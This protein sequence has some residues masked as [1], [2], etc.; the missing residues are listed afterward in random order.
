MYEEIQSE[1]KGTTPVEEKTFKLVE[2][3]KEKVTKKNIQCP[4]CGGD[5]VFQGGCV[6]CPDCGWSRCE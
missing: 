4:E 5:A 2:D 1:L 6:I 3:P